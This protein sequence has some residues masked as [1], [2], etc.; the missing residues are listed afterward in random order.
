MSSCISS[1][2]LYNFECQNLKPKMAKVDNTFLFP[3][4]ALWKIYAFMI[5]RSIEGKVW[6]FLFNIVS[7]LVRQQQQRIYSSE[8]YKVCWI[9]CLHRIFRYNGQTFLEII[10]RSWGKVAK[11]NHHRTQRVCCMQLVVWWCCGRYRNTSI[12]CSNTL[13]YAEIHTYYLRK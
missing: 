8:V 2:I 5:F 4:R 3:W 13:M 12:R 1:V 9:V 10:S 7:F 6:N 11:S